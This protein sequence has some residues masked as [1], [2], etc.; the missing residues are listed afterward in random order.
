MKLEE[1]RL[2]RL[3]LPILFVA[4]LFGPTVNAVAGNDCDR[5]LNLKTKAG[6]KVL[7]SKRYELLKEAIRLCPGYIR[8]Y[9]LLGNEYRKDGDIDTAVSLFTTAAELGSPNH[10]LYYW[11]AFLH[12]QKGNVDRAGQYIEQSLS[13][14]GAYAPSRELNEKIKGLK[15]RQGPL[16]RLYEPETG[17]V[18]QVSGEY[19]SITVRG[20]VTDKSG[21]AWLNIGGQKALIEN[22]GRFL[23][24]APLKVGFNT[25]IIETA[26]RAG[27][28]SMETVSVQRSAMAKKIPKTGASSIKAPPQALIKTFYRKSFAV[29]IGINQYT[30]APPL[31]FAVSDA[32]AV[33]SKLKMTGF[34]DIAVILD[35]DATQRRILTEL[36]DVLPK[37]TTWDDRVVFYFAGHGM[38]RE[39]SGGRRKGYII[40]VD[41]GGSDYP[42]TGI[43]MEQIRSLSGRIKAKH[44]IYIMDSCYSGLGFSRSAGISLKN[45]AYLKKVASRRVVQ[46]A[47]AG[48]AGEQVMEKEGH[49]L[50]TGFF[51]KGLDGAADLDLDGVV[52]GAELGAYLRP[53]V[54]NASKQFQTPLF[55]RLEGEGEFLFFVYK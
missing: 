40:P 7:K 10:K 42:S 46:I 37:K 43:S 55:G 45:E 49:G 26:D 47:T 2:A 20:T 51:L 54:S 28:R 48:G 33:Q 36:F 4:F 14:N 22:D 15:D 8:P 11:L 32:R 31:E 30:K 29:V 19:E 39:L 16:L 35:R 25:L 23:F 38:T 5:A 9:E 3:L 34:D 50:F 27:N 6:F 18:T 24:D 12:N 21:V 44:I 52:T 17:K 1:L 13:I 53:A 41:S